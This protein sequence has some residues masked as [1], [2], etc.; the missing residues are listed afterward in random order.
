MEQAIGVLPDDWASVLKAAL[1]SET[2]KHLQAFVE[3]AYSKTTVYP[4]KEAIYSAFCETPYASV[5]VVI[6]G[7]DPYHGEG[8]AHGMAFSVN[9]GVPIPP[10]LRNIFKEIHTSMGYPIPSDGYLG[11]WAEQGVLLLNTVLT[12]EAGK[13]Q[14]HQNQGWE[15]FTDEVI[16]ALNRKEEPIVFLLWGAPAK[17]KQQLITNPNH[18]V[19]T[20]AH[21][22]PLA[23]YRGF[24]GCNHFNKVN[25]YLEARHEQPIDWHTV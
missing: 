18:L 23:A 17:K 2:Y 16:R 1:A 21:P 12:V 11:H 8:Q 7:Q 15:Y 6:I 19:L 14:S 3:E 4:P 20:A 10:S 24:F 22:S 9:K 13:P 5:K 25:D